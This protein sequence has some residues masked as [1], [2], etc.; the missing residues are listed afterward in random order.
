L[1]DDLLAY[2]RLERRVLVKGSVDLAEIIEPLIAERSQEIEIRKLQLINHSPSLLVNTEAEGLTQALRNLLD[3]AFKFTRD[4]PLPVIDI[5]GQ[6]R[7]KTVLLWV[8]DNGIG[9]DMKYHDRIFE[10]FQRLHRIEDFPGTGIGLAIVSK[11]MQRLGGRA[12]AESAPETGAAFF[13]EIPK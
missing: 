10:I 7:E 11:V 3:N 6:E 12:W 9:F 1:I 13:L 2:S 5:G 4:T 8:K